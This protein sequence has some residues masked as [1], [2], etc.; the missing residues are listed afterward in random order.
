VKILAKNGVI[1]GIECVK[2]ILGPPGKDGRREPKAVRNSKFILEVDSVISAIG[3][4]PDLSFLPD[5]L[6]SVSGSVAVDPSGS[7]AVPK[8]FAGGDI[9]A[10]P[11]TVSYAIGSGKKAAMAIHA[12]LC[13]KEPGE[14][15]RSARQGERGSFSMARFKSGFNGPPQEVVQFKNLNMAYFKHQARKQK[16]KLPVSQRA[17]NFDEI[18]PGLSTASALEEAKRCFN[19]GVCNLCH[20]CFFLCP[21]LA[22]SA[23]PDQQGY[24]INYDYCK[25]CCICIEECPR[26]AIS[27]EVKP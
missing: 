12:T 24:A 26:G 10:Q 27:V 6:R 13:G 19:C 11:R 7:T 14:A 15:V 17:A 3:E 20:N 25:G 2:N 23:R 16:E 21:D 8:V 9:V 4:A 5:D 22:I 1:K 18:S